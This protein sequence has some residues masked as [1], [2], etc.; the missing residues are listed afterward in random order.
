MAMLVIPAAKTTD[1]APFDQRCD[2]DGAPYGLRFQF[3]ERGQ[4][5][6]MSI[7][8]DTGVQVLGAQPILNNMPI[9]QAF[10]NLPGLPPGEFFAVAS[11]LPD[12]NAQKADFGSRVVLYY[13]E[14]G[15]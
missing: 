14:A 15:A 4:T 2:L 1:G 12:L 11:T 5:W 6:M 7:F 8:D 9:L 3:S 10:R 13:V